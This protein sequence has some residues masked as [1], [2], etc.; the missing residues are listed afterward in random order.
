M[1]RNRKIVGLALCS[2]VALA[3]I[4]MLGAASGG[5]KGS[6]D[7]PPPVLFQNFNHETIP[8]TIDAT[9][10]YSS[11]AVDFVL[12]ADFNRDTYV[13]EVAVLI[14]DSAAN[15]MTKYGALNALSNGISLKVED[16]DGNELVD[17]MDDRLV[18]TNSDW[19]LFGDVQQLAATTLVAKIDF[20]KG[21]GAIRLRGGPR[22]RDKMV[23]ALNDSFTGLTKHRFFAKGYYGRQS[24]TTAVSPTASP[25]YSPSPSPSP[26]PTESPSPT[27]SPSPTVSPTP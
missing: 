5:Q 13:T 22:E 26:S 11:T 25:T 27:A 16:E 6:A 19:S 14:E 10:D 24:V 4:A 21:P 18:T 7:Y 2:I 15:D 12:Q 20:E 8:G 1:N 17:L 9:G 23:M 3:C